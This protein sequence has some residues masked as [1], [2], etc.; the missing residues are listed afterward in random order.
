M[1]G[2]IKAVGYDRNGKKLCEA[3]LVTA[4]PAVALKLTPRT[5]PH[6]WWADGAD[7]A[8]VDVEVVDAHGRRCPTALNL[9]QFELAGPAEWRG[10]IAQ[11][12]DNYI[13][14]KELPVECG[15]NRVLLRSLPQAGK[16]ILT[17][18]AAG[19]KPARIELAS[20]PFTNV[21]GLAT[22]LPG[23]GLPSR[24][25]RGPTPAGDSVTPT[26]TPLRIVSATAGT[27]I[28]KAGLAF[29]DNEMTGWKN[30]GKRATG[31]IQFEL[32]RPAN[33]SEVVLKLG[34][35]R[36]KSY[37]LRITVDGQEVWS[38]AT[39][40]SLGYVT[41]P[42]KATSGQ[43][44]RLE[45]IGAIEEQDAFGLVEVT[46]KKLADATASG[47]PGTLEIIE[48]EIYAPLTGAKR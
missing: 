10:G 8:L 31:W 14:A 35:W 45:L 44:V 42:L 17:A 7:V 16:I 6:G 11:G 34:G 38:G 26:R 21:A 29:D 27:D 15:V 18:S 3:A 48:A 30:D 24:L 12:P 28:A 37:P 33:V 46:G 22:S 32:E 41:L 47:K 5:A 9:V 13:R 40:K 43:S 20:A 2:E 4:G 1:A 19:L 39:P 36:N 23:D 25:D